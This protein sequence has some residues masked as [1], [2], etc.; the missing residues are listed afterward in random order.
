MLNSVFTW[1]ER[2]YPP[3]E[4]AKNP[5]PP[6]GVKDF[7]VYFLKQFRWGLLAK[8]TLVAIGATID[9]MIPV[10]LG[11]IVDLVS[12]ESPGNI[13]TSHGAM[14]LCFALVIILRPAAFTLSSLVH[15][16]TIF[17]PMMGRT[18]W[19]SHWHVVRQSWAYF[20]RDFAGRIASKIM[21]TGNS[22]ESSTMQAIDSV[23]Y[24]V[25][26]LIVAITVL[27]NVEPIFVLPLLV[28]LIVYLGIMTR[29]LPQIAK[30]SKDNS[31]ARSVVTGRI[32]DCYTNIQTLKTFASSKFEDEYVAGSVKNHT[33]VLHRLMREFTKMWTLL[34]LINAVL[35][36]SVGYMALYFWNEGMI[37]AGKL[38]TIIPF[39]WQTVNISGW[40][41]EV[42][43]N[44][45]RD[46]GTV[47]DGVDTIARPITMLDA[48]DA[49][50][51]DA[52]KAGIE[53]KNVHFAYDADKTSDKPRVIENLNLNIKPG[54]KIGL[55]GRSGAGK[56]TLI[57]LLLRLFDAQSGEIRIDGQRIDEVT[58]DSLR[59]AI[60][61]VSQDTSLL[62]RSVGE[63][64]KYGRPNASDEDMIAAAKQAKIHD[65]ILDLEDENGNKGYDARVGERGVKL[66]GGQRQRIAI[67]R[68]LLK[69]APILILDEA[70]SALDSEVEAAIQEQL[71][72]LMTNKTVIAIAHR[73]STI[74]AMDRLLVM[75]QGRIVE[76]GTHEELL[77]A[78]GHYASLWHRQSGGFANM[79]G[80]DPAIPSG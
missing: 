34:F 5:H 46:Y 29:F 43:T 36:V 31:E 78:K 64:I 44:I 67:A 15:F 50:E 38:A 26:F 12:N 16:H 76:Q 23:W 32:V 3:T 8:M 77:K 2:I 71:Q 13:F 48:D 6:Q 51:L 66:S 56:S 11:Q 37:T 65:V 61:F 75:D 35:M 30:R 69:D 70:T 20:Q 10:F 7:Y 1:F 41:L 57:N 68:V 18:R 52:D 21:E 17:P 62:H 14:L 28:W 49:E 4:L 45:F 58:Q 22:L 72:H 39:V 63:N 25:I 80:A 54:E 79:E 42:A 24:M 47:Q 55:I 33:N 53:F 59:R 74:A 9:A 60:G 73:L 19:Q 27:I 40:I